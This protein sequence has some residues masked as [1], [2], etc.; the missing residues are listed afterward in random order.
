MPS[1]EPQKRLEFY[2]IF[3]ILERLFSEGYTTQK[4]GERWWL[5]DN[6]GERVVSG[7][8]FRDLCVNIVLRGL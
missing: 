4:L 7:V 2:A 5:F 3:D 8:T 6:G 1:E